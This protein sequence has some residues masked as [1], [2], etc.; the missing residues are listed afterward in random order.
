MS[1]MVIKGHRVAKGKAK[2]EALVSQSPLS[3][4]GGVDEQTGIVVEKGH[5]LEGISICDKV[6]VFPIGKGS[7]VGSF[8]LLE[9]K[10]NQK[11]PKAI[12]NLRADPIVA[13]GAIVS[14]IPM[15]DRL[16]RNPLELIKT[17]DLVEVDADR[18][19]VKIVSKSH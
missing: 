12:I 8:Q 14:D 17:G 5:E 19:L 9:L 2:G 3:F 4:R 1:E 13:L 7:T 16:A 10:T 6:L 11:A 18:G 15:V